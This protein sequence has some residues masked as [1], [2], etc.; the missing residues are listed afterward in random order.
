MVTRG[1]LSV[2]LAASV[3]APFPAQTPQGAGPRRSESPAHPA[4]GFQTAENCLACHNTLTTP[5]G[6]DVSI[7]SA[8]RASMM[9]NS[10][11]DPY[12]QASVRRESIDHRSAAK[13]IEDECSICHMP[14]AR[15][16][17]RAAGGHGEVFAHLPIGRHESPRARLAADGVSCTLCH[18]I[19]EDGLGTRESFTGRFVVKGLL[20]PGEPSMFGPFAVDA[21]RSSVMR[22]SSGAKPAES[23]HM[24]QSEL[25][26]T[27]H[28]L[29]TEAL[30]ADGTAS[31]SLP[32]Q[33]PFL[34]WQ[35]SA[36]RIERSCQSCHMPVVSEPTPASSVLG[37]PRDGF[38]RH[39]FI[40]GNFFMLRMFNRFRNELG[41]WALPLELE[42]SA[43]AT[44]RQLQSDTATV[45]ILNGTT[46]GTRLQVDVAVSNL[47]G[48]KLPTGYPSRR[49]WLHLAVRDAAGRIVFESGAVNRA[50]AIDGNANDA[51]ASRYEPHYD[52][53]RNA[54][55]VQ[56]Y[57]SVMTD[58]GGSVTTGLLFGT[59]FVKDNR[60]LPRG[61]DK[62]TA[63]PDIAVRG[64]ALEDRNFGASGDRVRFLPDIAGASG[65]FEIEVELRYQPIGFRW[66]QNLKR[67]D[68]E[69]PRRFVSIYEAMA[70]DSSLVLA[71]S[72]ARVP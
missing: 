20:A 21:G 64:V 8:W 67:Y 40:G 2:A 34:E 26:A 10:A 71:R 36:F 63:G 45:S 53:I 37:E 55:E 23:A 65:P 17:A 59:A 5:A 57:E 3:V 56:I 47:T 60:L 25:C 30:G 58:A 54:D 68:A 50:G 46:V 44:V 48:H 51:D 38:S 29:Y 13:A 69:E 49:A 31:G 35:H 52:E 9:A 4:T 62:A 66:A 28:T 72:T 42:A 18:Q 22:S 7:G 24:R 1:M 61:F 70:Q 41:V 43:R 16:E 6:E 15:T 33:V 14:M 27:C 19:A 32:E 12:W 11:R 39:T